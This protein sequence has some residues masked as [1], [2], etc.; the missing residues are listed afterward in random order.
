MLHG[1]KLD[2]LKEMVHVNVTPL[3]EIID[4]PN[5]DKIFLIT[6]YLSAGSLEDRLDETVNTKGGLP[7]EDVRGYFRQLISAIHYCHEVKDVAHRGIKP[8]NMM[9]DY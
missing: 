4:D 6:Q 7:E 8:S 2:I 9:V 1:S 5:S 3:Y